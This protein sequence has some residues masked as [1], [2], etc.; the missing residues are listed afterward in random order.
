MCIRDSAM[1]L[2]LLVT[3]SHC[4]HG[5]GKVSAQRDPDRSISVEQRASARPA[6][7]ALSRIAF[8]RSV[9][10]LRSVGM[11]SRNWDDL[12]RCHDAGG[13]RSYRARRVAGGAAWRL[14]VR[15]TGVGRPIDDARSG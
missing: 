11:R 7:P 4:Y 8:G 5:W 3:R 9:Y 6:S 10:V 1:V 2:P 15:A 12:A 14:V 13:A